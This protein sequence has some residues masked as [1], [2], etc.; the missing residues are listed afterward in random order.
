MRQIDWD[1]A[2]ANAAHIAHAAD[3]PPRW[4]GLAQAWRQQLAA[5]GRARLNLPYGD[6][7][8][9]VW[10]LFLPEGV[11]QG[12][13]VF[14]HGGYWRAFDG[15]T[16]SYLAAGAVARGWAVAMPSYPLAPQARIA[17]ITQSIGQAIGAAAAEVAGPIALAGHSAGGHLVTRMVCRDTPLASDVATRI[18]R[19]LSISGVHDLRPLLHTAMNQDLRL[20]AAEAQA[21]SPLLLE[22]DT[23]AVLRAWVGAQERPAFITQTQALAQVWAGLGADIAAVQAPEQ[24]HFNVID[25]LADPDSAMVADWLGA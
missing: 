22:P 1:D 7:P 25:A 23:A 24:H 6:G 11:P 15:Q 3:Y 12:L 17:E 21:E 16:W 10:D 9:Q 8:R 20:D 5:A 19:V 13:A 14:V 18:Q 2:Y 4:Q